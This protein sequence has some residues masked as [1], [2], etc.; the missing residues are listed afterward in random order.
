MHPRWFRTALRAALL[1]CV[2]AVGACSAAGHGRS[3][4]SASGDADPYESVNRKVWAFDMSLDRYLLTPV[5]RGYRTVTPGVVQTAV[6]NALRNLKS[7]MIMV[8]D[9][10]QGNPDR[11]GETF[12][13]MWMNTILGLGGMIDVGTATRIPHH[14]A[15]FGQ[16]LG[17]WGVPSG[18]YLVLPLLGP[19]DP[20]D[21]IGYAADS[22]AD[23]FTLKLQ[24]ANLDGADY[25]RTGVGFVSD[26]A[27]TVDEL[28]ELKRSS[29]DFYAAVRSL[30]QQQRAAA[31]REGK[32]PAGAES[33]ALDYDETPAL[34]TPSTPAPAGTV[35]K[36]S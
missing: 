32:N 20:R 21:G 33:P 22:I 2:A 16:T 24:A 12:A 8:N 13:R 28:D 14:D 18:P 4:D 19:S 5:G 11:F 6:A 29:L 34:P 26:R 15:D 27:A 35:K 23:P 9:L 36:A 7:P 25:V 30:Y 3:A 1:C 10:L 31:V 17:V